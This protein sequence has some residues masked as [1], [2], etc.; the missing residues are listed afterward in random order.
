MADTPTQPQLGYGNRAESSIDSVNQWMRS[1]PWYQEQLQKWGQDPNN[2]HLTDPEKQDIIKLAQANGVVVDEGHNGQEIDDSGNFQAKS[3]TL[4]NV[5]IVGGLAAAALLTAGAAGVFGSA[6]AGAGAGADAAGTAA[7]LGGVEA[8]ATAGLGTAALPGAMAALPAVGTA[9]TVAGAAGTAAGIADAAG[10][11]PS[12]TLGTGAVAGLTDAAPVVGSGALPSTTLGTGAVT[13][14][15]DATPVTAGTTM[16][17]ASA[18]DAAGNYIGDSSIPGA[19]GSFDPATGSTLGTLGSTL[20]KLA[21]AL[22]SVGQ[23]IGKAN[24]A[25]GQNR[26]NQE[27]LG[28]QANGQ[29]ITGQSAYEQELMNRAK[30]EDVQRTK[31]AKDVYRAS[32]NANPRVSP[33]DPAGA[34][35]YSAQYLSTAQQLAD[36]GAST[37]AAPATYATSA[38]PKLNPYTPINPADVQGA[39]NT[40]QGTASKIGDYVGPALSTAQLIAKL[41]PGS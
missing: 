37:L 28:L 15:T 32:Y 14:L 35:K 31:A 41:W 9:G 5:M 18:F 30:E 26:L 20:G 17:D 23:A 1:Q 8:G 24:T 16:P 40:Q 22:G 34:P 11:L 12:T 25:A 3:H 29:N 38:Q 7:G 21:P 39:T 36:Q 33:F 4:R 13:G 10:T 2:V 19:T 6:A 27:N